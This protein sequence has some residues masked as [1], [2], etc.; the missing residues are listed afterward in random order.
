MKKILCILI[1]IFA[2]AN[3]FAQVKISGQL[4]GKGVLA[5]ISFSKNKPSLVAKSNVV[6]GKFEFDIKKEIE[7]GFY[8]IYTDNPRVRWYN[9]LY[10]KPDDQIVLKFEDYN[11]SMRFEGL[12][13]KE[14]KAIDDWYKLINTSRSAVLDA[15]KSL[16]E[17]FPI[18]SDTYP[19][20]QEYITHYNRTGNQSFDD[21]FSYFMALESE[22][23][24]LHATIS[25]R[26]NK[27]GETINFPAFYE[28]LGNEKL[29]NDIKLLDIPWGLRSINSYYGA[30]A[31]LKRKDL[32]NSYKMPMLSFVN[33]KSIQSYFLIDRIIESKSYDEVNGFKE[34]FSTFLLPQHHEL[35]AE[36]L[37]KIKGSGLFKGAEAKEIVG[38]LIDGSTKKL[39]DYLGKLVLV[40]VWA[41]W[42]GPCKQEMPYF[43][44][45]AQEMKGK[46]VVFLSVSIDRN[47]SKWEEYVRDY[48][49]LSTQVRDVKNQIST[50][51]Q[52]EGIPRFMLF[53]KQGKIVS[54]YAPR[55]SD[56][57]LK[58][59]LEKQLTK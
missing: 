31:R 15:T 12:L 7:A 46:D 29:Y 16:N 39:S 54:T 45:L 24:L 20:M 4:P 42:C 41:T 25:A 1:V 10:L 28:T 35:L 13:S 17:I 2:F 21:F 8:Y 59:L 6:E 55:P 34:R 5:V 47:K 3:T 22:Y 36:K 26:A 11:S 19:K 38:E 53:D 14:N 33:N 37:L 40:D 56:P 32:Q 51:Y 9:I 30:M 48:K 58:L 44:T 23:Y 57:A 52:I 18:L 43:E 49:G 27:K 50:D